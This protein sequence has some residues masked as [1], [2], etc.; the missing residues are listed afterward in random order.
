MSNF[1][2]AVFVASV[3]PPV[4]TVAPALTE[5]P[6]LTDDDL[7]WL[8]SGVVSPHYKNSQKGRQAKRRE[9][10]WERK[11]LPTAWVAF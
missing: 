2:N 1:S 9:G 4:C 5:S 7:D 6:K 10:Q 8:Q 3:S 11:Y